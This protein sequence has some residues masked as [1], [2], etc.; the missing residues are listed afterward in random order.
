M[1]SGSVTPQKVGL[2]PPKCKRKSDPTFT[3][4]L[5]PRM[6]RL[7][8]AE[9]SGLMS[10]TKQ[11]P[12]QAPGT[13][14]PSPQPGGG[15]GS[16]VVL[17][18]VLLMVVAVLAW[19]RGR[20]PAKSDSDPGN[21]PVAPIATTINP[22]PPTPAV[23]MTTNTAP[24]TNSLPVIEVNK[25][26]MVTV[27]LDFGSNAPAIAQAL[28]EVER[29]HLPDDGQG[30]TFAILDA[31][32]GPTPEGKLH[33]SMHVS[34]EK[35]GLGELVF[36]R[37]GASLWKSR[38]VAATNTT[39]FR[40]KGLTIFLD[41]G[42]GKTVTVDGS[43][44]PLTLME[45]TIKEAGG[46]PVSLFWPDGAERELTFLYSACGCPV[47]IMARRT[48]LKIARTKDL[49]VIFPDDPEVLAVIHRL[50]GSP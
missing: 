23:S 18:A 48:G 6:V 35:P 38:I 1:A 22:A 13:S 16:W 11:T 34:M 44:N 9:R 26:L 29:R 25:A 21:A 10:K 27:E 42:T 7:E 14:M 43:Q 50:L 24:T 39:P 31:Y 41:D 12:G 2:L 45:A 15:S 8:A 40:G 17:G 30:R 20:S 5:V 32:G 37:T 33:L 19:L 36:A 49:P 4:G 28:R 46:V 47:K 3:G